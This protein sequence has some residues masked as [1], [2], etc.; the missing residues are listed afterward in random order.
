M[1]SKNLLVHIHPIDF[2]TT[3][4]EIG[5]PSLSSDEIFPN[6][7][8]PSFRPSWLSGKDRNAQ[9]KPFSMDRRISEGMTGTLTRS[10]WRLLCNALGLGF[11]VVGLQNRCQDESMVWR[12]RAKLTREGAVEVELRDTCLPHMTPSLWSDTAKSRLLWST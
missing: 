8:Y 9:G 4:A 1:F 12:D 3:N 6:P 2:D 11:V 10:D 7:G 5:R